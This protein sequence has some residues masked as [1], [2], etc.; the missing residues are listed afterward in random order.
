M[1]ESTQGESSDK[2]KESMEV[3]QR[4]GFSTVRRLKVRSSLRTLLYLRRNRSESHHFQ[5][6]T[7]RTR[8]G[9]SQT[10]RKESW[11]R[12]RKK[13]GKRLVVK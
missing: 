2:R 6:G 4:L 8:S 13:R 7:Y 5:P 11:V 3:L 9:E 1:T 10:R 12:D